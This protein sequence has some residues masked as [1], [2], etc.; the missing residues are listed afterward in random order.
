[1]LSFAFAKMG[2]FKNSRQQ[3]SKVTRVR[4]QLK[5]L[6]PKRRL[7]KHSPLI[8]PH[9]PSVLWATVSFHLMPLATNDKVRGMIY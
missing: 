9:A 6:K 1:M 3:L 4:G 8:L 7:L 2:R 5:V